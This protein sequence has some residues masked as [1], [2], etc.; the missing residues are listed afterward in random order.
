MYQIKVVAS[1]KFRDS[2]YEFSTD[3]RVRRWLRSKGAYRYL[4]PRVNG[5]GHLQV[6]IP[7]VGWTYVH[8]AILEIFV[9]PRPVGLQALHID[10]DPSNNRLGNL[11][12]GTQAQN[13][14]HAL[15]NGLR[16]GVVLD[17]DMVREMRAE[18]AAGKSQ[19][20]IARER[21]LKRCTVRD[22]VNGRT[23]SWV[24]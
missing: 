5:D 2:N 15:A 6:E 17:A 14:A 9:C 7:N 11:C 3:G 1:E 21:G 23:W 16:I 10:D 8:S 13:M 12:W 19:V 4:T 22:A 24:E 18:Y 20:Q